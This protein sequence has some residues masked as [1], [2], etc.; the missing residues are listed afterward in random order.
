MVTFGSAVDP[1]LE[2]R[3]R[4]LPV[5]SDVDQ[6]SYE[7]EI[8]L[9]GCRMQ[10]GAPT[11]VANQVNN[12]DRGLEDIRQEVKQFVRLICL[13]HLDAF[14]CRIFQ[15][16]AH[17]LL[18]LSSQPP[19]QLCTGSNAAIA[20]R[21]S[22]FLLQDIFFNE[23]VELGDTR[24]L[25]ALEQPRLVFISGSEAQLERRFVLREVESV[26]DGM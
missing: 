7:F 25:E 26:L 16:N 22:P 21:S 10:E 15:Q 6:S 2:L 18:L 8:V 11:V 9:E 19:L 24:F 1:S 4:S 23:R 14:C 20:S 13:Y 17:L 5:L 12:M 3:T